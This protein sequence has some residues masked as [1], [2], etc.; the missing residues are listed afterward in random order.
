VQQC[1]WALHVRAVTLS[2]VDVVIAVAEFE[3]ALHYVADEQVQL[4]AFAS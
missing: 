4:A 3:F 1:D 2:P